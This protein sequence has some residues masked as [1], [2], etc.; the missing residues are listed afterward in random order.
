MDMWMLGCLLYI[1]CFYKTPFK[2]YPEEIVAAKVNIPPN[3]RISKELTNLIF[4][5]LKANP[6]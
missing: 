4:L 2:G 1:L 5:L 3:S 6:Q